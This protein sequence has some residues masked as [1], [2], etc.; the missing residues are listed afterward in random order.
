MSGSSGS[1]G[2]RVSYRGRDGNRNNSGSG[3]GSGNSNSNSGTYTYEDEEIDI[4]YDEDL[5]DA[6]KDVSL[7]NTKESNVPGSLEFDVNDYEVGKPR[8]YID[9]DITE[10]VMNSADERL[11]KKRSSCSTK[12]MV[13]GAFGAAA[14][15]A[16]IIGTSLGQDTIEEK[17]IEEKINERSSA[18]EFDDH[19][20][21]MK[22][23][24]TAETE[25][26]EE[27][28][29]ISE[30]NFPLDETTDAG[31]ITESYQ[32]L[33][34]AIP[35]EQGT[36]FPPAFEQYLADVRA[37]R[38]INH[39]TPLFWQVPFAGGPFQNFM[40]G[41]AKKVLA[42]NHR[43]DNDYEIK[44]H[45]VGQSEYVNVDLSTPDGITHAAENNLVQ[46]G[47]ADVIVSNHVHLT[48]SILFG[49]SHKGR[50][51]TALR[52]PVDRSIFEYHFVM[53]TTTIPEVRSMSLDEF[54]TSRHSDK[55]WVTRFL[56]N[57]R[58]VPLSPEDLELA[59]E[60]LRRRCLIGL[61][62]Y[63]EQSITLFEEYFGW[64]VNGLGATKA[65]KN[66]MN[67]VILKENSYARD[68][69][70][71]V[72]NVEKGS[73]VYNKIVELNSYDMQLYWYAFDLFKEQQSLMRAR[74]ESL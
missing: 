56:I 52:H 61:H 9:D 28:S 40:S 32:L 31:T 49:A 13:V 33:E 24:G 12:R 39:E 18:F 67:Q 51:F 41:C 8:G 74:R 46:A 45:I 14:I 71:G 25:M 66:C 20:E 73:D 58:Q 19:D 2:G 57:K 5:F 29:G 68:A 55:D 70:H 10:E 34:T 42:S 36:V 4:I 27:N 62:E 3:S 37:P 22:P 38:N 47:L 59:K 69:Y 6:D 7:D 35:L 15:L 1:G 50:L 63:I 26:T 16:I 43:I 23:V 21:Y 64:A 60:I 53:S 72:G 48:T 17:K 30:T 54:V 65:H 11:N 44:K